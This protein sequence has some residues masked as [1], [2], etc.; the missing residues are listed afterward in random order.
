[1]CAGVEASICLCIFRVKQSKEDGTTRERKP[2]DASNT[3]NYFSSDTQSHSEDSNLQIMRLT[4]LI[5]SEQ[6]TGYPSHP[7]T[8]GLTL[9]TQQ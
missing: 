3:R 2:Y 4:S 6:D 5:N 1:L 9:F 7:T 8:R